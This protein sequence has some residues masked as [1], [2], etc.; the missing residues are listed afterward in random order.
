MKILIL[1]GNRFFGRKLAAL[2]ARGHE[3]TLLNRGRLDDGL[4]AQVRRIVCDRSDRGALG[5]AVETYDVVYDQICYEPTDARAACEI[6]AGRCGRYIFTSSQSV[7]GPGANIREAAF[8]PLKHEFTNDVASSADYAEAKRQCEA[9]FAAG[10]AVE[11]VAVRFPIVCGTD[12]YTGRLKWHVDH[13]REGREM[14]FPN[15]DARLSLINSDDA[16][17]ALAALAHA[18]SAAK[19][20]P[21]NVCAP[22]AVKLRDLVAMISSATGREPK[23]A[24]KPEEHSP[25]GIS[26]DWYMVNRSP[27]TRATSEWLPQLVKQL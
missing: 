13:V 11:T 22:D 14:F 19:F 18:P 21:I 4:G 24:Q 2:L 1:G 27:H 16:A 25:Y 5:R 26:A 6:F 10:S 3:V 15:L 9:I 7:Y 12:D 8:D 17:A 20:A 23:I